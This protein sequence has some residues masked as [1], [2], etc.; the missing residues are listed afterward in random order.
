MTSTDEVKIEGP[1][2][3]SAE[4]ENLRGKARMEN[5]KGTDTVKDEKFKDKYGPWGLVTGASAGIGAAFAEELAAKGLNL[6]LLARGQ[7]RLLQLASRLE[8]EYGVDVRTA[9]VD[10]NMAGEPA[11]FCRRF[12]IHLIQ[13][14]GRHRERA[15]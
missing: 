14:A 6:V 12:E 4:L 8:N 3:G 15:M 9:A 13:R 10:M 2:S 11:G 7:E 5:T 1:T